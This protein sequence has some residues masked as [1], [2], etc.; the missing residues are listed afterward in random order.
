MTLALPGYQGEA[1]YMAA[2]KLLDLGIFNFPWQLEII[3]R[4]K[5]RRFE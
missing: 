1:S 2:N 4:L 5:A 3:F